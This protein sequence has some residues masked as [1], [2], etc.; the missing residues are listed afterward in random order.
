MKFFNWLV[1]EMEKLFPVTL[2]FFI[3][4]G[5]ILL[6]VKL[7][8][9]DYSVQVGVLSRAMLFSLIAGKVVLLLENVRLD[10]RFPNW[11]RA[12]LIALKTG[13]YSGGAVIAGAIEKI[14]EHW[15][16][17]AGLGRAIREAWLNS[18]GSRFSATVLCMTLLFA[19]YFTFVEV[20]R[21]MG[22]GEIF[23]LLF[24]RP[25]AEQPT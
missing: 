17:S 3:G 1:Q 19:T 22:K 5:L 11:P 12:T 21:A 7:V 14:L 16:S 23:V 9:Q 25:R 15:R 10:Q 24:K 8:L 20:D 13:F 18:S 6:I 4:F 2:F